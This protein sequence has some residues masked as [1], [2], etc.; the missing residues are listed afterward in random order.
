M[1]KTIFLCCHNNNNKMSISGKDKVTY[2][3]L[4]WKRKPS[5][6]QPRKTPHITIKQQ[7]LIYRS[8]RTTPPYSEIESNKK[9][10]RGDGLIYHATEDQ[11]NII[12]DVTFSDPQNT[13]SLNNGAARDTA[14]SVRARKNYK[15]SKYK[16]QINR[17][18]QT[19]KQ[20]FP[21][22]LQ[23]WHMVALTTTPKMSS[24]NS[25]IEYQKSQESL[26]P[27]L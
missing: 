11:K 25:Q 21:E 23:W 2:H 26:N 18:S 10:K 3:V 24:N 27:S 19:H 16:T 12:F 14:N 1:S 17:V 4:S 9:G 6:T 8:W 5:T 22:H 13:T 7:R 15:I 20:R